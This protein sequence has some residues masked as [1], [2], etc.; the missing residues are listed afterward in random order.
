MVHANQLSVFA[1]KTNNQF[2]HW[3]HPWRNCQVSIVDRHR[4]RMLVEN[5][6]A[7]ERGMPA[8]AHGQMVSDA[9]ILKALR[10]G[11]HRQ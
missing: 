3:L 10:S 9:H 8:H 7:R 4:A 6:L 11:R 5:N 2:C 1:S